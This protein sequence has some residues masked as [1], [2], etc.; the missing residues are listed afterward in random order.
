MFRETPGGEMH[1]C[2][3]AP[4]IL[5][6]SAQQRRR[7][8]S[9]GIPLPATGFLFSARS[10]VPVSWNNNLQRGALSGVRCHWAGVPRPWLNGG[11]FYVVWSALISVDSNNP[12]SK[13][14]EKNCE[15]FKKQTEFAA[16][17]QLYI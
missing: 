4:R 10:V 2:S 14:L 17:Q 7:A 11:H 12:V 6:E 1:S 13:I 9:N 8:V 3:P 15:S 5:P 16:H